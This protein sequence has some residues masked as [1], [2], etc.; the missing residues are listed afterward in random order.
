MNQQSK[1]P[2]P[3]PAQ[4]KPPPK[5][6]LTNTTASPLTQEC[7]RKYKA[8]LAAHDVLKHSMSDYLESLDALPCVQIAR[9]EETPLLDCEY[10]T[11]V[12]ECAFHLF[13]EV[14]IQWHYLERMKMVFQDLRQFRGL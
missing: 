13:Q 9:Q 1:M 11:R 8:L 12:L 14:Q 2:T 4:V 3:R 10:E 7:E 5:A 6:L